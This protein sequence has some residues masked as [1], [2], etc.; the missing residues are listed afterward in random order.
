MST[1]LTS[2]SYLTFGRHYLEMVASMFLGMAILWMPLVLALGAIGISSDELRGDVPAL[3][4]LAMAT[5]MTIP[6]VAWM[7]YRGHSW[8]PCA[9]MSASMFLPTLA[10]I[11]L[12]AAGLVTEFDSLMMLEH[13]VMLP[14]MLVAMLLRRGEYIGHH[15]QVAA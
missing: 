13:V 2:R 5:S 14:A 11:A 9:E 3:H 15:A 12:L 7:R 1:P 6:M 4:L 10:V 8:L